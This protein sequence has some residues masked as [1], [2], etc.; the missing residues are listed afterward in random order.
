LNGS[1]F[2]A[3]SC[4][5]IDGVI[6]DVVDAVLGGIFVRSGDADALAAT[7]L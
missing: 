3:A 6:R 2:S 5:A 1:P 7:L 4:L